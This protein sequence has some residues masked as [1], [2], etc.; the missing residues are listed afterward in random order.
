MSGTGQVLVLQSSPTWLISWMFPLRESAIVWWLPSF[1]SPRKDSSHYLAPTPLPWQSP[2]RW[3][4]GSIRIWRP[5][6]LPYPGQT[7][8]SFL[9]TLTPAS[10]VTTCRGKVC[11]GS[12]ALASV[13]ATDTSCWKPVPPM[14]FSSLTQSF[15]L[16]PVIRRRGCTRV[17]SISICWTT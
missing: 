16:R 8:S 9:P 5:P 10:A 6:S 17:P 3:K 11:L 2:T 13:T 12:T 4:K 15:V 1:R 14:V 7:S